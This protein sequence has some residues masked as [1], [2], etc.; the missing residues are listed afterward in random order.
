MLPHKNGRANV[1]LWGEG[2]HTSCPQRRPNSFSISPCASF[3]K[4]N[5]YNERSVEAAHA[6]LN[7]PMR[8]REIVEATTAEKAQKAAQKRAKAHQKFTDAQRKKSEAA[9]RYQDQ[10]RKANDTQRDA[11]ATMRSA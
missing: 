10:L 9:Q 2:R 5:P 1:R 6:G 11:Q 8:Y 7:T 3:T 4:V